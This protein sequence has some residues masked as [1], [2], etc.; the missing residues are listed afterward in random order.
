MNLAKKI[1]NIVLVTG[2]GALT[3]TNAV[4]TMITP[5]R[6]YNQDFSEENHDIWKAKKSEGAE[7]N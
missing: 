4:S 3:L 5:D 2:I 7:K 1:R 6:L